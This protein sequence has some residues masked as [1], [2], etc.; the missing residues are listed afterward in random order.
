MKYMLFYSDASSPK[1]RYFDSQVE[2]ECWAGQFLLRN[3]G[4]TDDNWVDMIIRGQIK[5]RYSAW[6]MEI[7]EAARDNS[8]G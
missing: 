7:Q 4:N 5:A 2:A 1:I 6:S 3:Q 8:D